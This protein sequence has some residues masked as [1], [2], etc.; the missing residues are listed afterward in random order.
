MPI[1]AYGKI[2]PRPAVFVATSQ[3]RCRCRS[4]MQKSLSLKELNYMMRPQPE[5]WTTS[6]I[7]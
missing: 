5:R 6:R 1:T 4:R 2:I 7:C 3:T